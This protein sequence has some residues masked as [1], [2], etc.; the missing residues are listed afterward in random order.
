MQERPKDALEVYTQSLKL[1]P[2]NADVLCQIGLLCLRQ[3]TS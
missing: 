3:G 2:G 1:T